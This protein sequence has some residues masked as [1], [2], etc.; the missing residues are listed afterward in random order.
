MSNYIEDNN[1]FGVERSESIISIEP[2][3]PNKEFWVSISWHNVKVSLKN[4][5][6]GKDTSILKNISGSAT[7]GHFLAILGESG[8]GKT[9]LLNYLVGKLDSNIK[10]SGTVLINGINREYLKSTR[11]YGFVQ[12]KDELLSLFTIRGKFDI[13]IYI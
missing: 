11:I 3:M 4:S 10:G 8:A 12:Q 5:K 7:P 1:K 6:K 9:T 13:Y 2:L